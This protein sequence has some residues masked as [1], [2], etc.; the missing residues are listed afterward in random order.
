MKYS[1]IFVFV[2]C[3]LG[4]CGEEGGTKVEE[5]V[6]P[7]NLVVQVVEE[8]GNTGKV[9]VT[10]TADDADYYKISFG[11]YTPDA[12]IDD[13]D[14]KL[15]FVYPF[16]GTYT[17]VVTAHA[18]GAQTSIQKA[19]QVEVT[20]V[21]DGPE[22][23]LTYDGM[24]LVWQNEFD[25]ALDPGEW[26]FE[27]G[28]GVNGWGNNELQYYRA[29]NTTLADGNLIITAKNDGFGGKAY[30]SSR[31]I[32]KDK[33]LFTYGRVD[34]RA[35]LPQG[36][37]IWPALWTLGNNISEAG[38]GWPKCGEIDIMEMVGGSG[39]EKTVL[40]TAHW[41]DIA[42]KADAS[43]SKTLASGIYAD[44]YHVFSLVR[45][46]DMM[47]WYVDNEKFF[48]IDITPDDNPSRLDEFR[49]P[50]FFIFNVAVGGNWP[51]SPDATTKFPQRMVVDYIRVFEPE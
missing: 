48:E 42:N 12:A 11:Y 26:T 31:I 1:A 28:N 5:P 6:P 8:E 32:T 7:S 43:G 16:S 27:T 29:E 51:G 49:T 3:L 13:P 24:Q 39:R 46:A 18:Y 10:A 45:T 22:S 4:A 25:D 23:P 36:Q 44:Q 20:R 38:V 15:S 21:Y 9:S 47:T 17:I 35:I 34:I 50:H 37:G 33:K 14:G 19:V 30:T 40:G 2:A 41:Q